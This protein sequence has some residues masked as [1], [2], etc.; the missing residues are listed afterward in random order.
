MWFSPLASCAPTP[1]STARIRFRKIG[2]RVLSIHHVD[3]KWRRFSV[4]LTRIRIHQ[5]DVAETDRVDL[6]AR[7][8]G[9]S[10][11]TIIERAG[12]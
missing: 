2:P 11:L 6:A 5:P 1:S 10:P 8:T 3:P 12:L 7:K 4:A 9:I